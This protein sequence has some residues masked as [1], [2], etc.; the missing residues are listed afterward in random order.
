M[1]DE[2]KRHELETALAEYNRILAV[3]WSP[4]PLSP[5]HDRMLGGKKEV[6]RQLRELASRA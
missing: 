5:T 2:Q 4:T 3:F 1:P 6:E